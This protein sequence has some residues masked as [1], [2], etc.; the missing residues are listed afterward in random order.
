MKKIATLILLLII[1]MEAFTQS[2]VTV[3]VLTKAGLLQK[4]KNQSTTGWV[5]LGGGAGLT[6]AGAIVITSAVSDDLFNDSNS[7]NSKTNTGTVLIV[8]GLAAMGGS[9]PLLISAHR[10]HKKAMALSII[11][12]NMQIIQK[13]K[14]AYQPYPAISLKINF[15]GR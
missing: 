15:G 11:N 7:Y 3:P 1:S 6:I 4:S 9:I 8:A 14:W 5:L 13:G 10:N 12:E 2:N